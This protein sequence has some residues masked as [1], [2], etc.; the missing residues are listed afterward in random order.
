MT[1]VSLND[2]FDLAKKESAFANIIHAIKN[3]NKVSINVVGPTQSQKTFLWS[4]L[5]N[6]YEKN[7][8]LLVSDELRARALKDGFEQ[9]GFTN[10]HVFR[11]REL[12]LYDAY[13]S[14]REI[15]LQRLAT[16]YEM[17]SDS[18]G[19]FIITGGGALSILMKRKVFCEYIIKI[20]LN[21]T[22]DLDKLCE[23]L[24]AMGYERMKTT[25][26]PGQFARRGDIVDI[27]LPSEI[28]EPDSQRTGIR[29]SF[30]GEGIDSIKRYDLNTQRSIEMLDAIEI[31]PS[32]EIIYSPENSDDIARKIE[33]LHGAKDNFAHDIDRIRSNTFFPGIDRYI[34]II[35]ENRTSPLD[36]F[37][38]YDTIFVIDEIARVQERME[39]YITGFLQT[40]EFIKQKGNALSIFEKLTLGPSEVLGCLDKKNYLLHFAN[41]GVS[42]NGLPKSRE[43]KITG[44]DVDIRRGNEKL[45]AEDI[46]S[47]TNEGIT[48]FI[49]VSS[50]DRQERLKLVLS[51]YS[52][53]PNFINFP[54]KTGFEYL[55]AG[56]VLIGEGQIFGIRQKRIK[57]HGKGM[58]IDLF[59][60]LQAGDLVVHDLHGI[61]KYLGLTSIENKS[62]TR[63]YLKIMY[64]KGDLLYIS[65]DNLDQIQK[66]VGSGGREPTLS[67]LGG[68]EWNRLKDNARS[69]IKALA[70]DLVKLYAERMAIK[71]H[72]FSPDTIWQKEFEESFV[73]QETADQERSI[74]EIKQDMESSKVMDRL[75]CGD[76]GFGKTEVAFRAMFKCVMDGKQAAMLVP[77]TVLA[78]QHFDTLNERL[79]DF[80]VEVGILSR[81]ESSSDIK[82]SIKRIKEGKIDIVIGTHRIL[83]KDIN[84]KNLGLLVIDEEQRFGVDHK[85]K[86][87]ENFPKVDVLTLTATPIPRT[88]Q[89]SMSGIRD[90]SI[91]EEAPPDRRPVQ[92]Y[93]ME[94]DSQI[95]SEA[96][97]R[98]I[99]RKGQV[100]YLFNNTSRIY[101]KAAEIEDMI[102]GARVGI[103]HG[104]MRERTLEKIIEE[105]LNKEYDVLVC[106]TI[107]ESG[108]DMPNVNTIIIENAHNFGLS[109]LYQLKGRV[110]RSDRQAYAYITYMQDKIITETAEKRLT[111]I[112]DYTELGSGFKIALKDLEVRGAG[113]LLGG[114]QHGNLDA[115]GY[116]LYCRM[117]E[118]E[119]ANQSGTAKEKT[120]EAVIEL[121]IDAYIP[122]KFLSLEAERMDMYRR[123]GDI[124]DMETYMDVLDEITDRFGEPPENV[125]TLAR[126]SFI[127][128]VA[129]RAGFSR[130]WVKGDSVLMSYEDGAKPDMESL[131]KLI[132]HP[133]Y[134][135]R[136]LFNAG[137]KPYITIRKAGVV[138][139]EIP[140]KLFDLLQIILKENSFIN[141]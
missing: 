111:A 65:M 74:E 47:Y 87:K 2:L 57:R 28:N 86:L 29:I 82:A 115:I 72:V 61:G 13:A 55:G 23:E 89:M 108:V 127:R 90:I 117:L 16:L 119:I 35:F 98:E 112:R 25:D 140:E 129:G 93:V 105:F 12:N 91:L 33:K 7:I 76:V 17:I 26:A 52:A 100:F 77:T 42:G 84:F 58:T 79:K 39:T 54:I 56:F 59:S 88:L 137:N 101:A 24:L 10:T 104:Q 132:N 123:I 62:G 122:E 36:Y 53:F 51:E 126:I 27:V 113:N 110:G 19:I 32:R 107:I 34:P 141:R 63:D 103:A 106:T 83:S 50:S 75:L 120:K 131:S 3:D 9:F 118:E 121:N 5:A 99:S 71:G 97:I 80:P 41:L 40:F 64:L 15:E 30:F 44:R 124:K 109:Q 38:S 67:R 81:F 18:P 31:Y 130:I 66:Y 70:T 138:S 68:Q 94:Y 69:S 22:Y 125:I 133:K 92:T 134:K 46:V 78:Q 128:N 136:I 49:A 85:E 11:Q 48:P 96:M 45:L 43:V 21:E 95:I 114:Q 139:K 8:V 102:P 73:F 60:D 6:I 116:D 20:G 14:S 135:G 37:N 1:E 4:A